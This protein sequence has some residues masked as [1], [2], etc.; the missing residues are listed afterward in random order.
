MGRG[1]FFGHGANYKPVTHAAK[2]G[3]SRI[4]RRKDFI[5]CVHCWPMRLARNLETLTDIERGCVQTTK[6]CE[7]RTR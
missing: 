6:P 3:R 4:G 5:Y 1:L 2:F 7:T